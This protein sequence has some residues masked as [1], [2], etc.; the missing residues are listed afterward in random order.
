MPPG[1]I[2]QQQTLVVPD[3]GARPAALRDRL[4][5]VQASQSHRDQATLLL[6]IAWLA[7]MAPRSVVGTAAVATL[8]GAATHHRQQGAMDW[9][10]GERARIDRLA[11]ASGAGAD[12]AWDAAWEAGAKQT[13]PATWALA[14]RVLTALGG[15]R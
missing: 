5:V 8:L 13:L 6:A 3:A 11:A 7:G 2:A 15:E 4:A 14:E 1:L 10:A 12:A 9:W